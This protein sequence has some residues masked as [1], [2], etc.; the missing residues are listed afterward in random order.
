MLSLAL[1]AGAQI[2][3]H[4]K[5]DWGWSY[6]LEMPETGLRC[7][8]PEKP[9]TRTLAYGY[10]TSASYKDELFVAAKL[11]I[12]DAYDVACRTEEFTTELNRV[13]GLPVGNIE[14]EAVRTENGYLTVSGDS[15]DGWARF[16]IDAIS[17]E[18]VLTIFLHSHHDGL[19]V[20]GYFFARSYSVTD[21]PEGKFIYM[22]DAKPKKRAKVLEYSNGR[23]VVR[24]ENS[25]IKTEWPD[26]P[27]MEVDKHEAAY[28]LSKG[29]ADY[30]M[31]II[32]LEPQVSYT[33]FNTYVNCEHLRRSEHATEKLIEDEM[34]VS[35][36]FD[37][38]GEAYFR[39]MAYETETGTKHLFY[40]A[41]ENKIIVQELNVEDG[42]KVAESRF[43]NTFEQA[44]RN[45]YDTRT[46]VSK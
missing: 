29:N 8:F 44:V 3:K 35:S 21:M 32:E 20:P 18:N 12:T 34:D 23:S 9:V 24:L 7:E 11:E 10:M 16:H 4:Q 13:Y 39:K 40:V 28:S 41:A 27:K 45:E 2:T 14:W 22:A 25:P 31:R 33:F 46:F 15:K 17:T 19:S 42:L 6:K 1:T 36:P 43:L 37:K 26:I 38:N 30:T 5:Y